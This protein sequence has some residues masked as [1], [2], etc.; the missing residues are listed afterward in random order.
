MKE[1]MRYWK[2]VLERFSRIW[3]N[4]K[5]SDRISYNPIERMTHLKQELVKAILM[6]CMSAE[7]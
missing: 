2:E 7:T 5:L 4:A 3:R 6:L 1:K